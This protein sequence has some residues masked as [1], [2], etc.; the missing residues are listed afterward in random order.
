[1]NFNLELAVAIKV[2]IIFITVV[3]CSTFEERKVLQ[4]DYDSLRENGYKLF[5]EKPLIIANVNREAR[6]NNTYESSKQNY[7]SALI[8]KIH[9]FSLISMVTISSGMGILLM[10]KA[11]TIVAFLFSVTLY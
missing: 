1:M 5:D 2:L 3:L 4:A 11:V 8:R 10:P 7:Y 6:D 9:T